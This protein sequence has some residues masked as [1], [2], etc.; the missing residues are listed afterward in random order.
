MIGG[1]AGIASRSMPLQKAAAVCWQRGSDEEY[2]FVSCCSEPTSMSPQISSRTRPPRASAACSPGLVSSPPHFM[3][4]LNIRPSLPHLAWQHSPSWPKFESASPKSPSFSPEACHCF[5]TPLSRESWSGARM[6]KLWGGSVISSGP[7]ELPA[8]QPQSQPTANSDS[9]WT[10]AFAFCF[11]V[12]A[13]CLTRTNTANRSSLSSP[14]DDMDMTSSSSSSRSRGAPKSSTSASSGIVANNSPDDWM[15]GGRD[16]VRDD[17]PAPKRWAM[18]PYRALAMSL[19]YTP[20]PR[21]GI[22][23]QTS[24]TCDVI[25]PP[26]SDRMKVMPRIV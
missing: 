6:S 8:N 23:D 18:T 5:A 11:G 16:L 7:K 22:P 9:I 26:D 25:L 3:A 17:V 10:L 19:L 12:L 13:P 1:S 15:A 21:R 20:S 2:T 14:A 4:T 24:M